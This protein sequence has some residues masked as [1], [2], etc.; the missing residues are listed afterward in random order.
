MTALE[1]EDDRLVRLDPVADLLGVVE[2]VGLDDVDLGRGRRHAV[3]TT[4][5]PT[6]RDAARA[7]R[8][9]GHRAHGGLACA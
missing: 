7:A 4:A 9:A 5:G 8:H 2:P 6:D 3:R 1:V